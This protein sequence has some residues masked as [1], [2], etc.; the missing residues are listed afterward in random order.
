MGSVDRRALREGVTVERC[1]YCGTPLHPSQ[2]VACTKH[3]DL[4]A[5]DPGL[6]MSKYHLWWLERYTR[7]EILVLARS[8][9]T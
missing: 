6:S 8:L 3:N 7:D 9:T 2:T 5:L 1:V 4:P